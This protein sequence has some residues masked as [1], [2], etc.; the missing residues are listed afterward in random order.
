MTVPVQQNTAVADN[1]SMGRGDVFFVEGEG[2]YLVPIYVADTVKKY[3]PNKAIVAYKSHDE[4]KEMKE[5]AFVFSL[6]PND[7]VR[8]S[9]SKEMKFSLSQKDS[10]LPKERYIQEGLFY[11]RETNISGASISI[12]NHDSTYTI[13][14]LGVKRLSMIEKYQ[15][16]V[17]GNISKV[18][19]EKRVGFA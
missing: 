17:L 19:K 18:G 6:Y 5:D 11:Y 16:D 7:L 15:V 13:E 1:G 14:S 4:W 2:Y 3:L 10:T 8:I 12:I 9:F